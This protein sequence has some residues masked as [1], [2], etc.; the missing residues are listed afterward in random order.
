MG[1][2]G[3]HGLT[4]DMKELLG[5][6]GMEWRMVMNISLPYRPLTR[7]FNHQA[8]GEA[9]AELAYLNQKGHIDAILTDD[10]D[11]LIFG[12]RTIIKK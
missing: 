6:F 1:K 8:L 10:C 12:G 7:F 11:V 3:S 9:E 2:S 5:A 4:Q